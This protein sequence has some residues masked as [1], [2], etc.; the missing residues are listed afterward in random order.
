MTA[1]RVVTDSSSD[2]PP[3]VARELGITVIPL[4]VRF[5]DEVYRDGVDISADQFYDKL[6]RSRLLPKTSTPSPG[7]FAQ[8]YNQLASETDSIL[9]I[10]LSPRYSSALNAAMVAKDYVPEG[11]TVKVIDS[12]SVSMGCGLVAIAAAR[13]AKAGANLEQALSTVNQA[14][15]R[16]HIIGMITDI[17]YLLGGQ[18][19]SLPGAHL[20]LGKV[21]TIFRFKLLGEIYEAGKVRGRGMYFRA[22]KA[23]DKL[24]KCVTEFQSIEELAI[25]YAKKTGWAQ[26]FADRIASVPKK[27]IYNARLGGATGVH[28]GP[29]A[30]A[31]AFIVENF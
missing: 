2:I 18:R 13:E 6:D 30:M 19:L 15:L 25:L 16:T 7:D 29:N 8:V 26:D 24:E 1:V 31:V 17:H 14:I 9:S 21:G 27:R 3:E 23:L 28:G 10:H 4:Y 22:A 12:K 5:G 11:C 20:F